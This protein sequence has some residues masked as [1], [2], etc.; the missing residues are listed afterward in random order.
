MSTRKP[1]GLR[2]AVYG[3][4]WSGRFDGRAGWGAGAVRPL[5]MLLVLIRDLA[6][7]QL[8]L[9]ATGLVFTTLLSLVPLLA[10]SFS[11]LKAFGVYNQIDPILL[12]FLAPLGEKSAD[13]SKWLIKFIENLNVK[14]LGSIGLA[15]LIYTVVSLM[16]KIEES[17]NFIWHVPQLRSFARRFSGYLSVLLIGPVLIFTIIG[18]TA[19]IMTTSQA[20]LL[21]H[22]EPIGGVA[23]ALGQT[24]P[25]FFVIAV[26]VFAYRFAPNTR[27]RMSAAL[28]GGIVAGMLWQAASWAFAEFARS[29]TQYAAIYSSFAIFLL[30]LIWL[31][32]NWLILLLGASIAFYTQNPEYLVLEQGEPR[33][34]NRMRERV[35]LLL[36]YLIGSTYRDGGAPWTFSRLTQ[37]LGVP[38]YAL[39]M[40]LAALEQGGLLLKT[41]DDPPAYLPSR[42]I[43]SI[44]LKGILHVV[45]TAGEEHY[46]EPDSLP[47]PAEIESIL[48]KMDLALDEQVR[49]LTLRDLLAPT[50]A[51]T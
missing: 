48:A 34:S 45:R 25:V 46:L 50:P 24:I 15:L 14:V 20:Q 17:V 42:D 37:R 35:A 41:G 10:L 23:Y 5:R 7:G 18:V 6:Y 31:Y 36:M 49:E 16:Q 21:L 19:T 43:G 33:L 11:V 13:V 22:T 38:S 39:Q 44:A 51:S 3:A 47:A 4:I 8:T 32:L 9:R 29:S 1:S 2:S 12:K 30:F 28:T 26:F 40:V 27:V